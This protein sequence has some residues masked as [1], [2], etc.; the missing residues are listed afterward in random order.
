METQKAEV[1]KEKTGTCSHDLRNAFINKI[2][3]GLKDRKS[4]TL[5]VV[6]IN[7]T[8]SNMKNLIDWLQRNGQDDR[9][10]EI[11]ENENRFF[12]ISIL[13]DDGSTEIFNSG[14]LAYDKKNTLEKLIV[15]SQDGFDYFISSMSWDADNKELIFA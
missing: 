9:A 2:P 7:V 1:K 8:K 5:N 3:Q 14:I 13:C 4:F 11:E 12:D 10:K 6:K 15:K